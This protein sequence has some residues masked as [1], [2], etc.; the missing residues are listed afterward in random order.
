MDPTRNPKHTKS[1]P[2]NNNLSLIPGKLYI[3]K[4]LLFPHHPTITYKT[5]ISNTNQSI[6]TGIIIMCVDAKT[7]PYFTEHIIIDFL[8]NDGKIIP[9]CLRIDEAHMFLQEV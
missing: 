6:P 7:A 4:F 3:T 5:T 8:L 1:I 2:M 9:V